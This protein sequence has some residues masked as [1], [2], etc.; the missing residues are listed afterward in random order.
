[1]GTRLEKL[2]QEKAVVLSDKASRNKHGLLP[3]EELFVQH[4][5]IELNAGKAAKMAYNPKTDDSARS[6]GYEML[7]LPHITLR[8]MALRANIEKK[9]DGLR[10][11]IMRKLM[12]IADIDLSTM[13][14]KQ[15]N[16]LPPAKWSEEVRQAIQAVE[17]QESKLGFTTTK[18]VK[19]HDKMRALELLNKMQGYDAPIKIAPTN[20]NGDAGF[21]PPTININIVKSS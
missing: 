19:L 12:L 17:T 4:Y 9:F 21:Q 14:D 7:R 1:M 11:K 16:L 6:I 3:K 15:G 5:L 10:E 2:K 8:I 20:P 18:K 13:Y